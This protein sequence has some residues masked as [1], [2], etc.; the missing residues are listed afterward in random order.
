M[1]PKVDDFIDK[2]ENWQQEFEQLRRIILDCQLTEEFKWRQ[3]CYSFQGKN[4]VIIGGFK[5]YCVLSFFKGA[6][7]KDSHGILE[8]IGE[9]TQAG[10]QIKFTNVDE[11]IKLETILKAYI[12]EAVEVEKAG[13]TVQLK[14]T[15]E[16]GIPDEL[17]SKFDENPELRRA[18]ES[19]TA[20]R[21]KGYLL[22]FSAPKQSKTRASRIK[23]YTQ[24]I[25][26][27][28]GFYDCTCGL[29]KRMPTCDGSHKFVG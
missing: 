12:F 16:Y 21:Q 1:N 28:K 19:L 3:P 24:K 7:L 20:G 27:G 5:E 17:R 23:S 2:A 25:L 15:S 6:L 14:K 11:I 13:L 8:R 4:S 29:S 9:H 22:Y 18:F 10:R 26:D